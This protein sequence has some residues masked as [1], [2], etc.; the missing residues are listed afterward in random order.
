MPTSRWSRAR[1]R[2]PPPTRSSDDRRGSARRRS[3]PR[4]S[5]TC[6][7]TVASSSTSSARTQSARRASSGRTTASSTSSWLSRAP[8][9]SSRE[10]V[11]TV[12]YTV[13]SSTS[14]S[15]SVRLTAEITAS[16][17]SPSS[18]VTGRGSVARTSCSS[19]SAASRVDLGTDALHGG[20][21]LGRLQRLEDVG[22]APARK[23][24]VGV[25]AAVRWCR[26]CRS[27]RGIQRLQCASERVASAV[28]HE[29]ELLVE[30]Y[31]GG[32]A[33]VD[34]EVGGGDPV[35]GEPVEAGQGELRAPARGRGAPGR[36]RSRRSRRSAVSS[37]RGPWSS[38]TRRARR[39][40]S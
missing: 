28:W 26:S 17:A 21:E 15:A 16:A 31:G 18:A 6:S 22:N 3:G 29:T 23:R 38:R 7:L 34:V 1:R 9:C 5:R 25:R 12:A 2:D 35:V 37:R 32:V 13:A 11:A 36:R 10:S 33:G 20:D 4:C 27:S 40:C 24:I 14:N 39:R 30:A 8:A 19:N